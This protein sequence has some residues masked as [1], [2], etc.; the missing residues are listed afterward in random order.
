MSVL[1][2]GHIGVC[3]S[4]MERALSFYCDLLGFRPLT[5]V[6]VVW[7]GPPVL[8][9]GFACPGCKLCVRMFQTNCWPVASLR[10]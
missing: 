2:V 10:P 9:P 3:V 1:R 8:V 5:E 6:A 7:N 4:D